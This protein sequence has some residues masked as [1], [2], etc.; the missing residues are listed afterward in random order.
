MK[1]AKTLQ[2]CASL[3]LLSSV[4][5]IATAQQP[6]T[7][8][9]FQFTELVI[10][11]LGAIHAL[12]QSSNRPTLA[13]AMDLHKEYLLAAKDTSFFAKSLPWS[14]DLA[15]LF[16]KIADV[17]GRLLDMVADL[18]RT[19]PSEMN[20][21]LVERDDLVAR[22]PETALK[23]IGRSIVWVKKISSC[24]GSSPCAAD[25]Y[26]AAWL[27][28]SKLQRTALLDQLKS[29]FGQGILRDRSNDQTSPLVELTASQIAQ[30]LNQLKTVDEIPTAQEFL[31]G[32][33]K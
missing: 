33:P 4:V 24:P 11:R 31:D 8:T 2:V 28:L 32:Y 27:L 15:T 1:V 9:R 21:L 13:D 18:S 22:L 20:T 12:Q 16:T 25:P 26:P 7:E 17:Q 29:D 3:L 6:Q 23:A 19:R 5:P 30:L 10:R 14:Q